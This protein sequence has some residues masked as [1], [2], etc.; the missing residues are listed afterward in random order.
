MEAIVLKII[1]CSGIVLGLYF[2]FL[3]KEKTLVFNRFYLLLGLIF[4]YTIPFVAIETKQIQTEKPSLVFE[5]EIP[6]Q[7]LQTPAEVQPETFDY[8]Q[9]I[10]IIYIA[11]SAMMIAK[12]VYSIIK[13]KRLKG[14]KIIYQNRNVILLEKELAPFSFL[15]TIYLSKNY[16]DDRKID[17]RIFL[18]EEI[19]VK[20]KHSFD[21]LF[22]EVIKAFSWFNP[23]IYLY[24][25]VMITNHEFIADEEVITQNQN[26]KNYQELILNEVLKQQNLQLI[27]QFNFNN[28]KKRFKMMTKT[29]SRFANVKKYLAIPAFAAL[30][31]LFAEKVYANDNQT[32]VSNSNL[33]KTL[34]IDKENN[35]DAFKEFIKITDKYDD[36]IKKRDFERFGKEVPRDEQVKLIELQNKINV[37]EWKNLPISIRYNEVLKAIP[38][39]KQLNQFLNSKY[40]ITLNGKV[41][42]NNILKS[43]KNTD[44]Y[45][46][47]ILKVFPKNPDFGN[48][49]YKVTLY[50]TDFAKKFNSQK[51]I[52]VSFTMGSEEYKSELKKDT[53][54]PKTKVQTEQ[55]EIKYSYSDSNTTSVR[56]VGGETVEAVSTATEGVA[57]DLVPAEFPGGA[58][59]LRSF[60]TSIFDAAM[61]TSEEGTLKS[62]ITFIVDQNGKVKEIKASGTN[63]K[64]NN[65]AYRVTKL[66][67]DNVVWKP[68]TLDGKPVAYQY[69][70]PLTM[71]F[72]NYQKTQ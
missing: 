25:N 11:I 68:A 4:S 16:Y 38:T 23:F 3:D 45:S 69:K 1:L 30:A 59:K 66:A 56:T 32:A 26:I 40:N 62:T 17:N 20:Q 60:V 42:D 14:R 57:A 2:L 8:A 5:K 48:F 41:V 50:T 51:N 65:E 36:I 54:A 43:Y 71:T 64:F 7:V 72:A 44:F 13:I 39:Q 49:E 28:T 61:L 27:H 19:H 46:V 15:N 67:N 33:S 6:Q 63:E 24:K 70:L 12:M 18:H 53:I 58:G 35:T 29:N 34:N 22:I 37:T 9:L 55:V 47:Y 52:A 31:V 21:V 10:L